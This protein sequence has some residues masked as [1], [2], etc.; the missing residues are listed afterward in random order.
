LHLA[1]A[2]AVSDQTEPGSLLLDRRRAPSQPALGCCRASAVPRP[3]RRERE[4]R[5]VPG[6]HGVPESVPCPERVACPGSAPTSEEGIFPSRV[7]QTSQCTAGSDVSEQPSPAGQRQ[8]Q[9]PTGEE[10]GRGCSAGPVREAQVGSK[11]GRADL[12]SCHGNSITDCHARQPG[13]LR[14]GRAGAARSPCLP[15]A[16]QAARRSQQR[17]QGRPRQAWGSAP[18]HGPPALPGT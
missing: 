3:W 15:G 4:Q 18:P 6:E 13:R 1:G 17:G 8:R 7:A 2:A 5:A 14:Q 11:S 10:L 16:G 9:A 12:G